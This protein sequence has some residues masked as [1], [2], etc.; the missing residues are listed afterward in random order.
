MS[1]YK[2]KNIIILYVNPL[3]SCKL[4]A[5]QALVR[6]P[7]Y[8]VERLDLGWS[9][10]RILLLLLPIFRQA[11][12]A[13][14]GAPLVQNGDVLLLQMVVIICYYHQHIAY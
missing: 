3:G 6:H 10:L 4:F 2:K 12:I 11:E 13:Q 1:V 8:Y 7:S 14:V 5:H 9:D